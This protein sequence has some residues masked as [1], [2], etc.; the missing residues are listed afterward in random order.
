MMSNKM[1]H[2]GA[3]RDSDYVDI[4]GNAVRENPVS[5]ALIGMGVLWLFMGGH[6]TSLLGGGGRSSI[7]QAIGQNAQEA[8]SAVGRAAGHVGAA[9]SSGVDALTD[10]AAAAGRQVRDMASDSAGSAT[11]KVSSAYDAAGDLAVKATNKFSSGAREA[12]QVAKS[13]GAKLGGALQQ[14][15]TDLLERQPL[16][17]GAIGLA[18]GAGIASSFPATEVE[19]QVMGSVSAGLQEK[20]S[21]AGGLVKDMATAALEEVSNQGRT[22]APH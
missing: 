3:G 7:F 4:L 15:L 16:F 8:G 12:T 6:K 18:I 5:A 19:Q 13:S 20:I 11:E 9:I 17:L 22:S 14:N 21:E 2:A 1:S 10:T